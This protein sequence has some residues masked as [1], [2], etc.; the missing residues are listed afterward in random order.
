MAEE[1]EQPVVHE[2]TEN[3]EDYS[4]EAKQ[5]EEQMVEVPTIVGQEGLNSNSCS[6]PNEC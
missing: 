1:E 4:V 2:E 5:E 3:E 6:P